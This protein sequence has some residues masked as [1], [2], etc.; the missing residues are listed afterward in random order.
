MPNNLYPKRGSF[1]S[2]ALGRRF[3]FVK[4]ADFAVRADDSST[5]HRRTKLKFQRSSRA[6]N[7]AKF[8]AYNISRYVNK[9]LMSDH[10]YYT[11][12]VI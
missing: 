9:I 3:V 12:I 2:D 7:S 11:F 5:K 6:I 4:L 1:G 8:Y 10:M